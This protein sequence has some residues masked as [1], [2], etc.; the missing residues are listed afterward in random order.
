MGTIWYH[1]NWHVWPM[2][3]AYQPTLLWNRKLI[4]SSSV[5]SGFWSQSASMWLP[6]QLFAG[7]LTS[8]TEIFQSWVSPPVKDWWSNYPPGRAV[9]WTKRSEFLAYYDYVT[10]QLKIRHDI[11]VSLE[12]SPK[13]KLWL[14]RSS[15]VHLS[16]FRLATS[17]LPFFSYSGHTPILRKTQLSASGTLHSLFL[18]LEE[19][20]FLPFMAFSPLQHESHL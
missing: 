10:P 15:V 7:F 18:C 11:S 4:I 13:R 14:T 8:V 3:H 2:E 9:G 17:L 12:W 5:S 20:H 1:R 19:S 6:V 16:S